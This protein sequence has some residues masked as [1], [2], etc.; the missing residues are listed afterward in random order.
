MA[1]FGMEPSSYGSP[2]WWWCCSSGGAPEVVGGRDL[3]LVQQTRAPSASG[4]K[5]SW[6]RQSDGGSYIPSFLLLAS[7]DSNERFTSGLGKEEMEEEASLRYYSATI[8]YT[9][10][11][12]I[13]QRRVV[14]TNHGVHALINSLTPNV[15]ASRPPSFIYCIPINLESKAQF[16]ILYTIKY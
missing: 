7:C 16:S 12:Y 5:V 9:G 15:E 11:V 4:V 10:M 8:H 14:P 1:A 13:Q 3:L 2:P 6:K